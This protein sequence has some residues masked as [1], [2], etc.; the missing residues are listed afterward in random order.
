MWDIKKG[1]KL[2]K[3]YVENYKVLKD[4]EIDFCD[5]KGEPLPII[6]LAG[7]NGSGKTSILEFLFHIESFMP[8]GF[9]SESYLK[10]IKD[11]R[12]LIFNSEAVKKI[13]TLRDNLKEQT[14]KNGM[15]FAVF[16]DKKLFVDNI[17]DYLFYLPICK[18]NIK[19]LKSSIIT[20]FRKKIKEL[21]SF[22]R[23][24]GE[25]KNFINNL[26]E[27][28]DIYFELEDIDDSEKGKEKIIFKNKITQDDF[29]IEHLSSGEK[30]LL[31]KMLYL[32]FK[33]IK[34]KVILID[35]P[36]LSLHPTWQGKILKLYESYAKKNNCQIIIA[37]HS[38]LILGSAKNEYIR[39]LHFKD[40]KVNVI[41]DIF[42]YGRNVEWV[43]RD[44]MG[45]EYV[46]NQ[47]ISKEMDEIYQLIENNK[48]EEA[49]RKIDELEKVIGNNDNEI[50]KLRNE[51]DFKR[52]EF[53]ED[54]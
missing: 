15:G 26:L 50:L 52:I 14:E 29:D 32:Y 25:I 51:I 8:F 53:E 48:L 54:Y 34:D 28:M 44:V 5:E 35:E 22:S 21:D 31:S 43:L 1:L 7:V 11:N 30:T 17:K 45:L 39:I 10:M 3:L 6:V 40:N 27:D 47:K 9:I 49:E 42:S 38:P 24:L 41:K 2:K 33:D 19:D 4:F 46:R 13:Q 36:E 20:F 12:E 23:T 18:D 37:T 16:Y